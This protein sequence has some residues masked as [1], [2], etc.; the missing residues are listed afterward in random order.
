MKRI[1]YLGLI[2]ALQ[3]QGYSQT[4]NTEKKGYEFTKV[5][6]VQSTPV[7]DQYRS[8][9][10]WSF[11]TTAFVESELLRMGKE[12]IDLSEMYIVRKAYEEKADRYVRMQGNYNFA[13]GGALN[14]V[15][16]IIA[17]Y[18]ALPEEAYPG[19]SYGTEKH[20]HGELD[21]V[22]KAYVDAIITNPN[23][24]LS[25]AWKKGFSAIL[26]SYLGPI[27]TSFKYKE[28]TYTP[29]SF[30]K[31]FVP[32]KADEYVYLTSFTHHPFYTYFILEVPDNWSWKSF[33]N[34][35]LDEMMEIIDNALNNGYSITWAADVSEKGFSHKNGVA[36]VPET[37]IEELS[38]NERLKWEALSKEDRQKQ[39]FSFENP[40]P[41]KTIS[42][43]LRQKEFDNY[44]TT[45]DHG[46]QIVGIYRDQNG[47]KYYKIKN[48][49]GVENSK[50]EGYFFA[51]EAYVKFKTLSLGVHINALPKK[52]K[53]NLG[54]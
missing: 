4:E 34:V 14:D 38:G 3:N 30:A 54:R 35:P 10:C 50:Y 36:I 41:E 20:V 37:N 6:E 13:G 18:G 49:W 9:T 31:E 19:L 45:D 40:V 53:K 21:K 5:V 25:T 12:P 26:D 27:P 42:Q 33:F 7:K 32:I 47:V 1:V 16:D 22:L 23:K 8:G 39:M 46:M 2:L 11:A 51:S 29:E 15:I 17:K 43:E 24:E 44:K 28:K 52:T 48:S